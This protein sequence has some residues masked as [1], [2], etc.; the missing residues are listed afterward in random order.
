MMFEFTPTKVM[1][2][3]M[4]SGAAVS[5]I[6]LAILGFK[7]DRH[8][9][10]A[11]RMF[12]ISIG[13]FA[14]SVMMATLAASPLAVHYPII[15]VSSPLC[16]GFISATFLIYTS[17]VVNPRNTFSLRWLAL[18]VPGIAYTI[19]AVSIDGGLEYL[20]AFLHYG[21]RD[22][23]PVLAP[24]FAF[25]TV[26][27]F[28]GIAGSLI[29]VTHALTQ[30]H[31]SGHRSS[32]KWLFY[33]LC[34]AVALLLL[35][36]ILPLMGYP[37]VAM[38]AGPMTIPTTVMCYKAL[39]VHTDE[40]M[41][42]QDNGQAE[43]EV[44]LESLGRMA[45]GVSHDINNLL[46]GVTGSAE[47][48]RLKSGDN[49]KLRPH[50]DQIVTTALRA[51]QLMASMLSFSGRG[52]TPPPVCPEALVLEAVQTATAQLPPNVQL[53]SKSL[54]SLPW[55]RVTPHD[56]VSAVLNLI[57][58]AS[59]SLGSKK[60]TVQ[61]RVQN[62]QQ[63]VIPA[64]A[65]GA[66]LDGHPA[67]LIS[68]SDNGCGMDETTLAHIFEPF[69]STKG[70]GRGLGLM[71]VFSLVQNS[72]GAIVASSVPGQGTRFDLWLPTCDAPVPFR[73]TEALGQREGTVLL[74]ED[75]PAVR[76]VLTEILESMGM[77]VTAAEG[78]EEG[79][80]WLQTQAATPPQLYILDI[81]LNGESGIRLAHKLLA[82]DPDHQ[83]LLM[84]GDEPGAKISEFDGHAGVRF[85]RK[86]VNMRS[87]R[88]QLVAF[89]ILA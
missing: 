78:A 46:T 25:H 35:T 20:N 88:T 80:E 59:E 48:I 85:M 45:R 3:L 54:G 89:G 76:S 16:S 52:R 83:I 5:H 33:G 58:N 14:Y 65:L 28:V 21:R 56:L 72:D 15:I 68:V 4:G 2:L 23:H 86:P 24:M 9:A 66:A 53:E 29:L 87:L 12:A 17:S 31:S 36:N 50:I 55:V 47:L 43:V 69:F 82:R 32:L 10:P 7:V 49:P 61:V 34:S 75:D 51:G 11:K 73:E 60:G 42:A 44:R 41:R 1:H 81:R 71:S 77:T 13:L 63:A 62:L 74:V 22:L 18:G 70:S 6:W 84:S 30:T 37:E 64:R 38:F 39:Q 40:I 26:C 8:R 27:L 19:T 57:L 67:L 79:L